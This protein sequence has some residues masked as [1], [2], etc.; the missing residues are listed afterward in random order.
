[1]KP[2]TKRT[3]VGLLLAGLLLATSI[4]SAAYMVLF[5]RSHG[6]Y[7]ENGSVPI[8]YSDSGSGEPVILL[9]GFAVNGDLNWRLTGVAPR[10]REEY[11]VIVPDLRGHGLSGKPEQPEAYGA[12]MAEDVIHLMDHLG[13]ARAHVAGYSLGGYVALKLAALNPDR[14]LSVSVLGAGWQDPE[15]ERGEA[16]FTAFSDI[17][18]QLERGNSVN[19]V[20]TMFGDDSHQTTSWHR[21]QVRLATRFLG[22]KKALAAMLRSV[23]GL[24]LPRQD[25][26]AIATPML[27]VCGERDPNFTSAVNLHNVQTKSTFISLPEKSHPATA[28]SKELRNALVDFLGKHTDNV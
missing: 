10:L 13:I 20:G 24:S 22:N 14:L 8:F 28:M 21:L 26:A 5:H 18:N 19:P 12:E 6:E 17:A 11:R 27:I 16:I 2:R 9:H 15:T 25:V 3:I 1:M 23:R 7:F 4:L